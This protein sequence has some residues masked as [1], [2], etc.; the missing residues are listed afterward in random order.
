MVCP[1]VCPASQPTQTMALSRLRA[2]RPG[3]GREKVESEAAS[4]KDKPGEEEGGG[5]R[6]RRGASVW[7]VRQKRFTRHVMNLV[8]KD[9][10]CR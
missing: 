5:W 9:K 4:A 7:K 6:V 3:P 8:R 1:P 2:V 10:V